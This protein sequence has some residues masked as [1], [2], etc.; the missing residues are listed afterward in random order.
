MTIKILHLSENGYLI[1]WR[2]VSF[3]LHYVLLIILQY[4]TFLIPSK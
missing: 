1:Q 3:F 4:D 2:F